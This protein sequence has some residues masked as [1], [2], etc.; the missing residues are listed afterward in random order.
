[1]VQ[2]EKMSERQT[3]AGNQEFQ[4]L[5]VI[6]NCEKNKTLKTISKHAEQLLFS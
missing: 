5:N 6:E 4:S 2:I 1:M 3:K